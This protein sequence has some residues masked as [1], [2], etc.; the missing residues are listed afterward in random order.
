MATRSRIAIQLGKDSYKSIYCHWDGYP[1]NNGKIL[2]QH[3]QDCSKVEKL[4]ELGD[5]SSLRPE[6]GEKHSF[7]KPNENWCVSYSRDRG[8]KNTSCKFHY[9]I[10]E[11]CKEEYAYLY[12]LEGKWYV[13]TC[14]DEGNWKLLTPSMCFKI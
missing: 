13:W 5:L 6:I 1:G 7:D 4:M 10:N 2:L 9:S 3:Y 12:D 11:I 8:E 14:H